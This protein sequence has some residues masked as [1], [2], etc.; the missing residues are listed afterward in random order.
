MNFSGIF[1]FIYFDLTKQPTDIRDGMTKLI[2]NYTLSGATNADYSVYALVLHEQDIEM[3]NT[4][5]KL[6]LR[7]M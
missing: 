3:R 4:D 1:S 2:F 5:K 7:S 6:T